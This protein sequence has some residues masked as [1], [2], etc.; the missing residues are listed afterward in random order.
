MATLTDLP[1]VSIIIV[2]YNQAEYIAQTIDSAIKQDYT[3][4]EIIISDDCSTDNTQQIIAQYASQ[5]P[6]K[7]VPLL[8][9]DNVGIT[10]NFN[11]AVAR[12]NGKYIALLG[13]DDLIFT[14]KISAQVEAF[15]N[16][17]AAVICYHDVAVFASHNNKTLYYFHDVQAGG[18]QPYIGS[19]TEEL[20]SYR[21]FFCNGCSTMLLRDALPP[22]LF[23]T[24]LPTASDWLAFI[25]VST[26]GTAVYINRV[27]G[28]Y[29]RHQFNTTKKTHNSNQEELVY[30]ILAI[31]HPEFIKAIN[32]GRSRLHLFFLIRYLFYRDFKH[33]WQTLQKLLI[34]IFTR[35]YVT[36]FLLKSIIFDSL[37]LIKRFRNN[38]K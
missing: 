36:L 12:A 25:K 17:P 15:T 21:C 8:N 26:K 2:T 29:R 32:K 14:D 18:H 23:D 10:A 6:H 37:L 5:Y 28:R 27:L 33:A 38:A 20:I 1:L 9:A 35:P 3:N 7:I 16:T 24:R 31:E 11:R 22:E 30:Q 19:I 4:I 13:G 34:I